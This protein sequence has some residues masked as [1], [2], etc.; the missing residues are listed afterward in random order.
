MD[1]WLILMSAMVFWVPSVWKNLASRT[2]GDFNFAASRD[3][4]QFSKG[5]NRRKSRLV[6]SYLTSSS[7]V[8]QITS[9]RYG[10]VD[11]AHPNHLN[12]EDIHAWTRRAYLLT[13]DQGTIVSTISMKIADSRASDVSFSLHAS[14]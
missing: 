10:L 6:D 13:A 3:E 5:L 1:Q 12:P 9:T 8:K 14:I 7:M 11:S 4:V 2:H